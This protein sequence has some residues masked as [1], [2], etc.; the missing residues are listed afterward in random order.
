[1]NGGLAR[2]PA[3][4]KPRLCMHSCESGCEAQPVGVAVMVVK[5]S[6]VVVC[7]A[8]VMDCGVTRWM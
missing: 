8:V 7:T 5:G 1:M 2:A 3:L 4:L 6:I